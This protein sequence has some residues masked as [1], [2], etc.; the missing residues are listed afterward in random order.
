[1]IHEKSL[2][3]EENSE[4]ALIYKQI[5]EDFIDSGLVNDMLV[6][7]VTKGK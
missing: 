5:N 4:Q 6:E 1:M 2:E 7:A 3:L